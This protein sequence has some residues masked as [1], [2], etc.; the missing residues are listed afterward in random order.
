MFNGLK[1]E[2]VVPFVDTGW[3]VDHHV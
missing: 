2:M 1:W 3:I